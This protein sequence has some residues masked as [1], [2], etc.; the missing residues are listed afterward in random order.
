MSYRPITD[1]WILGRS[2]TKGNDG[3]NYYG[4][5]PAGFL[6]RARPLLVG[7]DHDASVWHIPGGMAKNYN[8]SPEEKG[9]ITLSGFGKNDK[10]IDIDSACNPDF[11]MDVRYILT[12]S[13]H[14]PYFII[15]DDT[16]V[17]YAHGYPKKTANRPDAILVDRPYSEEE[18][19]NYACGAEVF[20]DINKLL[21]DC[22]HLVRPGGHVGVIDWVWPH[23]G[24]VGR[25]VAVIAVSTGRNSRAR[26]FTVWKKV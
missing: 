14:S 7:G 25:E 21:K 9:G 20:P 22:L 18:A 12:P 26:F 23:A 24:K 8:G 15:I 4:A 19:V 16:T 6:E 5:Y 11:L 1:S 2:K 17:S 10:T 3:K 13:S